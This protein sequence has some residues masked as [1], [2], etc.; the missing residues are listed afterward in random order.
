MTHKRQKL[1]MDSRKPVAGV[2]EEVGALATQGLRDEE[3][4]RSGGT[5]GRVE[6][7]RVELHKL[8]P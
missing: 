6:A 1:C 2:V 4:A 8:H 7:G 3:G 5:V